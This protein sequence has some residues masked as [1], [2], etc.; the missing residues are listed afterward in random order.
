M[1]LGLAEL[2]YNLTLQEQYYLMRKYDRNN[3]W[4]L[5]MQDLYEAL[6]GKK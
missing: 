2:G 6:G 4:K 3:E 5:C 1:T